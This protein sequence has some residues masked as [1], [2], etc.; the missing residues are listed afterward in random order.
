MG[1]FL[2]I[3]LLN[4]HILRVKAAP[5][6]LLSQPSPA[7][8]VSSCTTGC[9]FVCFIREKKKKISPEAKINMK[10]SA[11]MEVSPGGPA[12]SFWQPRKLVCHANDGGFGCKS[13]T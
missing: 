3:G 7:D 9:L 6:H 10:I 4:G 12:L 8:H 1:S 2:A 11:C 5:L 13:K